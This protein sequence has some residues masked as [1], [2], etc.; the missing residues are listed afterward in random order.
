LITG[1]RD[2]DFLGYPEVELFFQDKSGITYDTEHKPEKPNMIMCVCSR[3]GMPKIADRIE[4]P[5]AAW[6]PEE[7]PYL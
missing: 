2:E 3:P 4:F 7:D 1:I 6:E 5:L